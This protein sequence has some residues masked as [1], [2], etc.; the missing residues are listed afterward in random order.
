MQNVLAF[1]GLL[2]PL[3]L[4][5]G[6]ATITL[7]GL[8][9]SKGIARSMP[10]YFGLI[11]STFLI[12]TASGMGLNEVFLAST[13]VYDI[14]RYAGIL[15]IIYLALKFIR[16]RPTASQTTESEHSLYDGMLLT[17]LNPKFYVMVTV[18][19]SQFLKPGQD[20]LWFLIFGLTAV[21]AFSGF[22]WLA[23]GASLRPLLRSERA[24][25]IQSVVFGVLLLFV[26]AYMLLK[27][28]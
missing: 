26:A 9:L 2:L 16:A 11:I 24:L 14:V 17:A 8:G 28:G 27:G 22:A 5:P 7:A 3:T 13:V 20:V 6:P 23:A 21:I 10:F 18:G 4:S 1:L 19:F 12:A 15:Y 25:R